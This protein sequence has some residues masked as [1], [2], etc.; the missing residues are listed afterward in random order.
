MKTRLL[1]AIAG[2]AF[3]ATPALASSTTVEFAS[4]SG[5]TSVVVFDADG[6]ASVNGAAPGPYTIDQAAKKICGAV[7]GQELCVTFG[8]MGTEVGFTTTYQ[9]SAGDKGKATITAVS[10]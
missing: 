9:N 4:D 6:T 5:Q 1:I 8:E 2:L 10:E 7:E 3:I